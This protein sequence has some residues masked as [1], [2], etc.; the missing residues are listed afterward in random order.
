MR[1]LSQDHFMEISMQVEIQPKIP[2]NIL[3]RKYRLP[4]REQIS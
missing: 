4:A 2:D 1:K 3:Q